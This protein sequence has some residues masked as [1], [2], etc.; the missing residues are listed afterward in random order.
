MTDVSQ[1]ND[2]V[3]RGL[4]EAGGLAQAHAGGI[5]MLM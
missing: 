1:V 3:L 5:C 2:R 4:A